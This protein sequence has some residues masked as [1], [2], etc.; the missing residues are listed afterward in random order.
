VEEDPKGQPGFGS[1]HHGIESECVECAQIDRDRTCTRSWQRKGTAP[2]AQWN[3]LDGPR[4]E[5]A[6]PV[7]LLHRHSARDPPSRTRGL[8][9]SR[10][11]LRSY[12]LCSLFSGDNWRVL[13]P[14]AIDRA[15]T[16]RADELQCQRPLLIDDA[17]E[18]RLAVG[19]SY[20]VT[21]GI[22]SPRFGGQKHVGIF[23]SA[24]RQPLRLM[25]SSGMVWLLPQCHQSHS[26]RML[27]KVWRLGW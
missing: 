15:L 9:R 12:K 5:K 14:P 20:M 25:A 3:K 11:Q 10:R 17:S 18:M 19:G 24:V 7:W 22:N 1:T 8:Q 13:E 4:R 6:V 21:I 2:P 27:E 16:T 26:G 23:S